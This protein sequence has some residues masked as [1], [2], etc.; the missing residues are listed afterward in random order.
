MSP[1]VSWN[2]HGKG[3]GMIGDDSVPCQNGW[4]TYGFYMTGSSTA[5]NASTTT[6]PAT[7]A[8]DNGKPSTNGTTARKTASKGGG[9][10]KSKSNKRQA[11]FESPE[12]DDPDTAPPKPFQWFTKTFAF[13][14]RM[15]TFVIIPFFKFVRNTFFQTR[16]VDDTVVDVSET[17]LTV[18]DVKYTPPPSLSLSTTTTTT[19]TATTVTTS[20]LENLE[21]VDDIDNNNNN[22]QRFSS[23][24]KRETDDGG[25]DERCGATVD[26]DRVTPTDLV[27]PMT[28]DN[29]NNDDNT[30]MPNAGNYLRMVSDGLRD[31]GVNVAFVRRAFACCRHPLLLEPRAD[32]VIDWDRTRARAHNITASPHVCGQRIV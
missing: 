27:G 20:S 12:P 32:V 3:A 5:S 8:K 19:P 7:T 31:V 13:I 21:D 10:V 23:S 17:H 15:F 18:S 6:T 1:A 28:L 22:K 24:I 26:D 11:V 14:K 9:G 2:L 29:D 16:S 25:G 30:L 4:Q